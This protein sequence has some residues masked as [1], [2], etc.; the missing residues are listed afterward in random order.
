M[1]QYEIPN[2]IFD[3]IEY[4]ELEFSEIE[5]PMDDVDCIIAETWYFFH[6]PKTHLKF[7]SNSY[8]NVPHKSLGQPI[9]APPSIV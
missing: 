2:Y 9:R 8:I 5:L 7:I 6:K 4:N 1:G 3:V